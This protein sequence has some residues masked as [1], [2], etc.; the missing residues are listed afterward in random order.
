M[1]ISIKSVYDNVNDLLSKNNSMFVTAEEFNRYVRMSSLELFDEC[2]GST[3]RR[4]DNRTIVNYGRS[5]TTDK[6]LEPFRTGQQVSVVS[7]EASLPS[8]CENIL[9]ITRSKTNPRKIERIDED[10]VGYLYDNV[11]RYP[12]DDDIYYM[13]GNGNIQIFGAIGSVYINYLKTPVT[14]VYA[15]RD[16]TITVGTRTVTRREYD[17]DNSVDLEWNEREELDIVNR[18]LA[19]I[20]IPLK[21]QFVEQMVNVNKTNE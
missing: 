14:P 8:D 10:R 2:I 19:K 3:N 9:S 20:G 21:D 13:E 4:L 11:F 5:Q 7:G 17:P 12:D 16:I 15:E 6:R 1:A 18:V